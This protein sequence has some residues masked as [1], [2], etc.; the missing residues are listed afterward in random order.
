MMYVIIF[1]SIVTVIAMWMMINYNGLIHRKSLVQEAWSGIDIQLKRRYD[2]IPN[3]VTL[4]QGYSLHEKNIIENILLARVASM[5][6]VSVDQKEK[7]ELSL[8]YSLK[9]LFAL[10]EQYPDLKANENFLALQ[11]ELSN[12]EDELQ[13][14]RRYYNGTVRHYMIKVMQFPSNIIAR[15][16]EFQTI[17]YFELTQTEESQVPQI[18]F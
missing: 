7:A 3:L 8:N 14:A 5:G 6:A 9:S 1:V 15:L 16:F 13:L 2:L 18:K 10:A 17:S 11:K 4:V 12:I